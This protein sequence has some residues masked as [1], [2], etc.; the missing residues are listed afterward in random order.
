MK[1]AS[2]NFSSCFLV[3]QP[4]QDETPK[5]EQDQEDD[6]DEEDDDDAVKHVTI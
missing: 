6:D 2:Y 1:R 4:Q 5:R 3:N